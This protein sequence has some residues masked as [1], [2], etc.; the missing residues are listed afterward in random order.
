MVAYN[1]TSSL[2]NPELINSFIATEWCVVN[3]CED[4]QT[5]TLDMLTSICSPSVDDVESGVVAVAG[6]SGSSGQCYS[7]SVSCT[8]GDGSAIGTTIVDDLMD[9]FDA[10]QICGSDEIRFK[11]GIVPR[12][13]SD[14]Q[15][16]DRL[17]ITTSSVG[18]AVDVQSVQGWRCDQGVA[19]GR[20]Y[21]RPGHSND[22]RSEHV[23]EECSILAELLYLTMV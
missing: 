2:I 12:D 19:M 9:A 5:S 1:P 8:V 11:A 10:P 21:S 6:W 20:C 4:G 13:V 15:S 17:C 7:S 14:C 22:L 23:P 3:R 18:D 16:A